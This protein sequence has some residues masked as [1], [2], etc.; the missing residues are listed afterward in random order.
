MTSLCIIFLIN[1]ISK[2]FDFRILHSRSY[3]YRM[4]KLTLSDGYKKIIDLFINTRLKQGFIQDD[5]ATLLKIQQCDVSKI[6]TLERELTLGE[7]I[8]LL[9]F[10]KIKY[11]DVIDI[12]L[13]LYLYQI[14]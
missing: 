6:E 5:I 7:F 9:N 11:E 8:I 13:F 2:L 14:K 10:F 4:Q 1:C 3:K 12:N